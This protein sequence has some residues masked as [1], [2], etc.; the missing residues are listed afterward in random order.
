[1]WLENGEEQEWPD[2]KSENLG[3]SSVCIRKEPLSG[4][5]EAKCVTRS[6]LQ[7]DD[8]KQCVFWTGGVRC[9]KESGYKGIMNSRQEVRQ[10]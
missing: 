1:M 10:I 3:S 4:F 2:F 5:G 8:E 7:G 6:Q 9:Q